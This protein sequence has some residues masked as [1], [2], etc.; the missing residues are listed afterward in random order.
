MQHGIGDKKQAEYIVKTCRLLAARGVIALGIDAPQRGER[1]NLP[2]QEKISMLDPA[3]VHKWFRQHCGDY[4][5]AFDYLATRADVDPGQFGYIGFSWGAITGITYAAHDERIKAMASLV[6]G[7]NL[8]GILGVPPAPGEGKKGPPSLD[9]AHNVAAFAPR[10]LRFVNARQDTI[11]FPPFAEALHKAAGAG[12]SVEW[13]D[14]DHYFHGMDLD[15]I[16]GGV[17]DFMKS[18]LEGTK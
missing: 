14:T 8:V 5:R 1:K 10:P 9:P 15:K 12:S 6:G 11:I 2:G 4:S 16:L 18:K 3:S 7:G 17:A 13:H